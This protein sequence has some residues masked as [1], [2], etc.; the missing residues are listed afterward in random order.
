MSSSFRLNPSTSI[1]R[2]KA[3]DAISSTFSM[4][5]DMAE[6][7]QDLRYAATFDSS[8]PVVL[9]PGAT[10]I[11][12]IGKIPTNGAVMS[13][14]A[15]SQGVA[16]EYNI[17]L[18]EVLD[19]ELEVSALLGNSQQSSSLSSGTRVIIAP[20]KYNQFI[21]GNWNPS[22]P[23]HPIPE[24][25]RDTA[26]SP[27]FLNIE[28]KNTSANPVTLSQG[29]VTVRLEFLQSDSNNTTEDGYP[30]G[31]VETG[32]APGF[33][34]LPS[35]GSIPVPP[36]PVEPVSDLA[37]KYNLLQPGAPDYGKEYK[38]SFTWTLPDETKTNM[39]TILAGEPPE[40][41]YT[42]SD[43]Y[44]NW[45]LYEDAGAAGWTQL[46]RL[47][48][49]AVTAST[50]LGI[51][52]NP[53]PFIP[54]N[55]TY[56]I[57]IQTVVHRTGYPEQTANSFLEFSGNPYP[58]P[59]PPV[60]NVPGKPTSLVGVGGQYEVALAWVP[61]V[62]SGGALITSYDVEMAQEESPGVPGIYVPAGSPTTASTTVTGLLDS[63]KY[64]FKVAA[65]NSVGT[66]L[67]TNPL[68]VETG[69]EGPSRPGPPRSLVGVG[70]RK[71][72]DLTWQPP[73]NDGGKVITGYQV[74]S[75]AG[76]NGPWSSVGGITTSLSK[77]I[78]G[79]ADN[80]TFYFK[81][82]AQNNTGSLGLGPYSSVASAKTLAP[83]TPK[84]P[85]APVL[86][87]VTPGPAE[88]TLVWEAP[89]DPGT[90][91][92]TNYKVEQAPNSG[93]SP[94]TWAVVKTLNALTVTIVGLTPNSTYWY[95]V[96]AT[97]ATGYGPTS[98]Q[99]SVTPTQPQSV[100]SAPTEFKGAGGAKQITTT[101]KPPATLGGSAISSYSV[102]IST[103]ASGTFVA[104]SVAGTLLQLTI[105][106]ISGSPLAE[107]TTYFLKASATNSTGT[108]PFTSVISV[109]TNPP[110][111]TVPGV[112][113][114]LEATGF[115]AAMNLTWLPPVSNGGALITSYT[116]RRAADNGSGA[117]SLP[118]ANIATV[119]APTDPTAAVDYLNVGL[120]NAATVFHYQVAATN[121]VGLGAFTAGAKGT[122]IASGNAPSAPTLAPLVPGI[123]KI[124]ATWTPGANGGV[125]L[126]QYN[127]AI[128]ST[129]ATAGF[130]A[131]PGSPITNI[132]IKTLV[133]TGLSASTTYWVRVNEVNAVGTSPWSN[134]LETK[135]SSASGSCDG[136]CA[137]TIEQWDGSS[138]SSIPVPNAGAK[139]LDDVTAFG[140]EIYWSSTGMTFG[141]QKSAGG[142]GCVEDWLLK[143]VQGNYSDCNVQ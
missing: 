52:L 73:L 117:P 137:G 33:P 42:V 30:S 120:P 16:N 11:V 98:T 18:S 82:A 39:E 25:M 96:S 107:N 46:I 122:T 40:D 111:P 17:D 69:P 53:F 22:A 142:P 35:P 97:N 67:F 5:T 36:S 21:S 112:P 61:P 27:R 13:S 105:T 74:Q 103:S 65:T 89:A 113:R 75:A 126:T 44:M 32:P 58:T 20:L 56:R 8:S 125:A 3:G 54:V 94:G 4:E 59:P 115:V 55:K 138:T 116:V 109:K 80:T 57:E 64:Y 136:T 95:R 12:N 139:P 26:N 132:A 88:A 104:T 121:S 127:V 45:I 140:A 92:I 7:V 37:V 31:G 108:G 77:I 63:T 78:T 1:T 91:T 81:V 68:V 114:D 102:G 118:Y 29:T 9:A 47:T 124:Q 23:Y 86:R 106:S 49:R 133:I 83:I 41:K 38:P 119:P 123:N 51:A 50:P 48:H 87:S 24:N 100:P 101:W 85:G 99:K 34:L 135:T 110:P 90:T 60:V 93:G 66:G 10:K 15:F 129:S 62:D 6:S 76:A 43:S 70:K 71:E 72:I 14:S 19:A 28:F 143:V 134:V 2:F 128:S 84:A 79:L 130:A 141:V 131:A